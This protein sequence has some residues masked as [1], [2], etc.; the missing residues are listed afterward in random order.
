MIKIN[1]QIIENKHFPDGTFSTKLSSEL[2]NKENTTVTW[3]FGD[4]SELVLLIFVTKHLKTLGV[5]NIELYMPYIPNAR[6]DRVKNEDDIFTLKYFAQIINDLGFDS[7]R[8]LDPH[9]YVSEA[10]IER[11]KINYPDIMIKNVLAEISKEN[12][13]DENNITMFYPDEGAMKRY[14]GSFKNPFAFG[15]KKRDWKSGDILG[16]EV[17][18]EIEQIKGKNILIVDDICSKGGTFYHSAKKLK[19][20][21]AGNIYL[22]VSH[23]ENTILDGEVLSSGLVERVYTTNSI[24]TK[25]HDKI[26]VYKL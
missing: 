3:L 1:G 9:S 8:V 26:K 13:I 6:L 22:Y 25:A 23:C 15:I 20:L 16:L 5:K 17:S 19:E 18:G 7:V 24:F 4:N 11:I 10:L 14:F 21:G 2:I 12:D